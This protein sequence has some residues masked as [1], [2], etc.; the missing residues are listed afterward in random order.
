MVEM[1]KLTSIIR[2]KSPSRFITEWKHLIDYLQGLE[3]N[4]SPVDSTNEKKMYKW[5][6][7]RGKVFVL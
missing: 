4:Y 1:A 6:G 2:E 7:G 5:G 3:R